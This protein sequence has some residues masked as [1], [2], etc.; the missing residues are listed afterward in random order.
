MAELHVSNAGDGVSFAPPPNRMNGSIS[1]FKI[2]RKGAAYL[3]IVVSVRIVDVM[4]ARLSR[5]A[6]TAG[7][8]LKFIVSCRVKTKLFAD[9]SVSPSKNFAWY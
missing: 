2:W 5:W 3:K 8:T 1:K 6:I 9:S 4:D 7:S